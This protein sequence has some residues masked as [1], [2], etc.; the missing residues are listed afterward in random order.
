[1]FMNEGGSGLASVGFGEEGEH[2]SNL[3]QPVEYHHHVD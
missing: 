3:Y 1:M 2:F